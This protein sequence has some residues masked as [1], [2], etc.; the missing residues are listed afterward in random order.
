[1]KQKTFSNLIEGLSDEPKPIRERLEALGLARDD[2]EGKF[3]KELLAQKI[4]GS[5][6]LKFLNDNAQTLGSSDEIVAQPLPQDWKNP[7]EEESSPVGARLSELGMSDD[8]AGS[9]FSEDVLDLSL[10]GSEFQDFI[11]NNQAKFLGKLGELAVKGGRN[12]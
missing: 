5:S 10:T 2:F 6:F 3:S 12:G 8:E 4:Y 11:I 9:L 1:M 7:F